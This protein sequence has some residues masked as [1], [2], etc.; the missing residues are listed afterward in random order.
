MQAAKTG[1]LQSVHHCN[2]A[3]TLHKQTH[4]LHAEL[5]TLVVSK[6]DS[7]L[8]AFCYQSSMK[9]ACCTAPFPGSVDAAQ[10]ET[11]A[12]LPTG[13]VLETSFGILQPPLGS[14][15]LK[16]VELL[17][18]MLRLGNSAAESSI[19]AAEAP[20]KALSL[21]LRFPFNNLLHTQVTS[22]VLHAL[23]SGTPTLVEHLF[24]G[25]DLLGWISQAPQEV[26]PTPRERDAH[27][28]Q[29]QPIRAGYLGHLVLL[30]NRCV[31]S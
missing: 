14:L 27:A 18:A 24:E 6:S 9:Y 28:A 5:R 3:T 16:L 12:G 23:D 22:L 4:S 20:Q 26:Q 31:T 17:S 13:R 8:Q 21:L 30:G 10:Y 1:K 11:P 2:L 15:R 29:R 19:I 25:C 7:L